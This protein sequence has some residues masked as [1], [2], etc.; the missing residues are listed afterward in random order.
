MYDHP[1]PYKEH[2]CDCCGETQLVP[3]D[4]DDA[5]CVCKRC[6]DEMR[7]EMAM[8][9]A[10]ERSYRASECRRFNLMNAGYYG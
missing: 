1:L 9:D 2:D 7:D 4:F 5:A 8:E 3:L 10:A 6:D